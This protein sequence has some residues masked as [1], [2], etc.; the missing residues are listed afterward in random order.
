LP[1]NTDLRWANDSIATVGTLPGTFSGIHSKSSCLAVFI[2]FIAYH[3][4]CNSSEETRVSC[5][6]YLHLFFPLT[7]KIR[8]HMKH[9]YHLLHTVLITVCFWHLSN[10]GCFIV[11][12]NDVN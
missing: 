1:Q 5:L 12:I 10:D 8:M 3:I 7:S 9:C 4:P 11:H 2:S 6:R